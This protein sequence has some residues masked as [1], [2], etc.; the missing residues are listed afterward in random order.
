MHGSL[1]AGKQQTLSY[2]IFSNCIH[3]F[4]RRNAVRDFSPRRSGIV[5]AVD[6]W[7][8]VIEPQRI[9]RSVSRS[10]VEVP[11]VDDR[12]LFPRLELLRSHISPMF[13]AI[14]RKMDQPV[15]RSS[16]NPL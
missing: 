12:D 2:R 14:G 8:Q 16:P 10:S 7:S 13:T 15:I 5:G 4:I 11:G 3:I 6:M 1:R 9:N